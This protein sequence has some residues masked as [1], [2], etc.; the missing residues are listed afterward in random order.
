MRGALCSSAL[1]RISDPPVV[2]RDHEEQRLRA[3]SPQ[4]PRQSPAGHFRFSP[5]TFRRPSVKALCSLLPTDFS[6]KITGSYKISTPFT[7]MKQ[8]RNTAFSFIFSEYTQPDSGFLSLFPLHF[9]SEN[10]PRFCNPLFFGG[11]P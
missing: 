7:Q 8:K 4:A 6:D 1:R 3:P 11:C 10:S 9:F 5:S 2:F